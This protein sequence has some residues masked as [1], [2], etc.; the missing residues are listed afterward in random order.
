MV[1]F[2]IIYL[3]TSQKDKGY[4]DLVTRMT[5]WKERHRSELV[6]MRGYED[7]YKDTLAFNNK[8]REP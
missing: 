5:G 1:I 6:R 3:E 2:G 7:G 8:P 4:A